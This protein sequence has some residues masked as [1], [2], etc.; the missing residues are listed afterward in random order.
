[1]KATSELPDSYYLAG[2]FDLKDKKTMLGLN[3]A[4]LFLTIF[5]LFLYGK[6][7]AGLRNDLNGGQLFSMNGPMDI[8]SKLLTILLIIV[9]VMVLHEGIH[10]FFF[11]IFT[12]HKPEFGIKLPYAYAAMPG[13]YFPRNQYLIIGLTPFLILNLLGIFMIPIVP[14]NWLWVLLA[15]LLLNS[16]GA[17]GDLAVII[18]LLNKPKTCLALDKADSIDL[19]KRN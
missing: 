17:V 11:W 3:I 16:S 14:L 2:T 12:K 8:V 15:A 13:W 19:Y 4:G 5:F 10:G 1:M 18:W 7:A 6:I 9:V